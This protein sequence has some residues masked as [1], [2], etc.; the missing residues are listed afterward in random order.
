M[1]KIKQLLTGQ[2]PSLFDEWLAKHVSE[3]GISAVRPAP[4]MPVLNLV[5]LHVEKNQNDVCNGVNLQLTFEAGRKAKGDKPAIP[6]LWVSREVKVEE[7]GTLSFP[8]IVVSQACGLNR[9]GPLAA[10]AS[11]VSY[12]FGKYGDGNDTYFASNVPSSSGLD[13]LYQELILAANASQEFRESLKIQGILL[14]IPGREEGVAPTTV[15]EFQAS[16]IGYTP[17][18]FCKIGADGKVKLDPMGDNWS[19]HRNQGTAMVFRW[20]QGEDGSQRP[21]GVPNRNNPRNQDTRTFR[22]QAFSRG[23]RS[24]MVAK[25]IVDQ[26]KASKVYAEVV[27]IQSQPFQERNAGQ[28][29]ARSQRSRFVESGPKPMNTPSGVSAPVENPAD[30]EM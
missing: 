21:V 6:E 26:I 4:A 30:V 27:K 24:E 20:E 9:N 11:V 17:F 10:H 13:K 8:H 23:R 18:L 22:G 29:T 28:Q 1:G 12:R 16:K 7:D 19:S 15:L 3:K 5:A 25:A 14:E 2:T